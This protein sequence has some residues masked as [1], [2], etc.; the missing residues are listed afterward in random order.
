MKRIPLIIAACAFVIG[1][2]GTVIS[3]DTVSIIPQPSS[4]EVTDG[5]FR[6]TARTQANFMYE[7]PELEYVANALEDITSEIF[8]EG[9]KMNLSSLDASHGINFLLDEELPNEGYKIEISD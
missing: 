3:N 1:C 8:G 2:T 4:L 9:I 6:L 5:T 7:A